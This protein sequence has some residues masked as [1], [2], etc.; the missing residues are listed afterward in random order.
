MQRWWKRKEKGP[1]LVPLVP[2]FFLS[3][4]HRTIASSSCLSVLYTLSPKAPVCLCSR[5]IYYENP[6]PRFPAS[7]SLL[8]PDPSLPATS[9]RPPCSLPVGIPKRRQ[10]LQKTGAAR[11]IIILLYCHHRRLLL[12]PLHNLSGHALDMP[13][14]IR[15]IEIFVLEWWKLPKCKRIMAMIV[16]CLPQFLVQARGKE[17]RMKTN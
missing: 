4:S 1:F 3:R 7:P 17:I 16:V 15:L 6:S 13:L 11:H 2:Y 8:I 5:G 12:P 9:V 10:L 14:C